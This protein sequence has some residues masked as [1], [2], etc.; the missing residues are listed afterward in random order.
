MSGYTEFKVEALKDHTRFKV[1]VKGW[2][3]T[4]KSG[5]VYTDYFSTYYDSEEDAVAAIQRYKHRYTVV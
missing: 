4:W 3:G 2:L 5:Y 1:L